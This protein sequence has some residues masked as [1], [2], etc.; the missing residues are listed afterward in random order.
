MRIG[1]LFVAAL[2]L[3]VLFTGLGRV[4]ALDQREARDLGV[5]RELIEYREALTPILGSEPLLDKP[6][7]AYAP[8][9]MV[10]VASHAPE[11]G[12]RIWRALAAAVL[13]LLT[14]SIG[15]RHLGARAGL[16][17][18]GV[19]AST[20]ALPLA[21]RT[22]GTQLLGS[23]LSW[24]GAAELAD[25]LFGRAGGRD[26][27]LIVAYGAL[28]AALMCAGPLP[29]LW[30]LVAVALYVRL[31]RRADGWS[32]V[33]ALAGLAIMAGLALPW[34]GAMAERHGW[35][36]LSRA[37]FFPYA[38][39]ARTSWFIGP[40]VAVS[41]LVVGFY[42]WSALLPGV[43]L[44]AAMWWPQPRSAIAAPPAAPDVAPMARE[45][46][47]EH[48]SHFFIACA[49]A[50]V[51]PLLLYPGPPL[52]AVL[53][54]LPALAL[55]SGRFLDHLIEDPERLAAPLARG[56]L[57]LAL[58]GTVAAV[59]LALLAGRLREAAPD[60]GLLATVVF[61]VAWLPLLAGLARRRLLAAL[62]MTLPVAAGTPLVALRVLP[63]MEGYLTTRTVAEAMNHR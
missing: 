14:G 3:V 19:L 23:L 9:V 42:P 31:A 47:H 30:P 2:C 46:G 26:A 27:R 56:L 24:L 51:L 53:P 54:A 36:F 44:H 32:R 43:F 22:D 4:G 12:S 29:A 16:C 1:L 25:A 41:F 55:L 7:L 10:R 33:R 37:P 52:P 39:G 49:A 61:V 34:Y 58:T 45:L 21:A 15:A 48:A 13:V 63:A 38:L 57:M 60:L 62:L 18:A 40:F 35:E 5:A 50:S 20:L 11:T 59:L 17:A 8:D 28:S 6:L